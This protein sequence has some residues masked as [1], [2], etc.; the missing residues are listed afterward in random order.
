MAYLLLSLKS[1]SVQESSLPDI[2]TSNNWVSPNATTRSRSNGKLSPTTSS[3]NNNTSVSGQK[4]EVE[5]S[6]LSSM[7]QKMEEKH[8]IVSLMT[9]NTEESA[10]ST[11]SR[12]ANPNP[13]DMGPLC[14]EMKAELK[15]LD[16]AMEEEESTCQSPYIEALQPPTSEGSSGFAGFL[17]PENISIPLLS[18]SLVPYYR[19]TQRITLLHDGVSFQLCCCGL[20]VRLGV[21][22][23][24]DA[25]KPRFSFV[26]DTPPTL[27]QILD[28]CDV[29]AQKLSTES[30]SISEWRPVVNQKKGFINT[31]T[32]RMQ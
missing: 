8:P 26:V 6:I 4:P 18:A 19:G 28:A 31:P 25:G 2:F 9:V 24:G 30:G 21:K 3:M 1:I 5:A 32:V 15:R 27:C 7:N 11:P 12:T 16:A 23:F 10:D 14:D 17:E 13:F 29:I 22:N 20:R